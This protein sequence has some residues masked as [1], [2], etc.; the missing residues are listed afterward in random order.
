[1]NVQ[2]RAL[3]AT[4]TGA[5]GPTNGLPASGFPA[6]AVG[7][8][9]APL[10]SRVRFAGHELRLPF[11]H[12]AARAK[13]TLAVEIA[14]G[15]AELLPA[16]FADVLDLTALSEVRPADLSLNPAFQGGVDLLPLASTL[17]G[18]AANGTRR[19]GVVPPSRLQVTGHRAI[20][21]LGP[22]V[23][24][25]IGFAAVFAVARLFAFH[26]PVIS[27]EIEERYCEMAA[28]RLAQDVLPAEVPE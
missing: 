27:Q 23:L 6:D 11:G 7:T 20:S 12:A 8:G 9:N 4:L 19:G 3:L 10:P 16:P 18:L 17:R 28:R 21:L 22:T 13:E 15:S 5:T 26:I 2:N 1:M 24:R 14:S 25:M